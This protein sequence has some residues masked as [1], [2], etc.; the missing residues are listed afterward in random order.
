MELKELIEQVKKDFTK[1]IFK[2]IGVDSDDITENDADAISTY[3]LF[4]TKS[5]KHDEKLG[6]EWLKQGAAAGDYYCTYRLAEC[7]HTGTGTEVDLE[8][9]LYWYEKFY[10]LIEDEEISEKIAIQNGLCYMYGIGTKVD[11]LKA[12]EWFD[13][14]GL[15]E[16]FVFDM[17]L[18]CVKEKGSIKEDLE[19]VLAIEDDPVDDEE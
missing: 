10:Y 11:K 2:E 8:K 5:L 14:E 13:K 6:F 4:N 18:E 15:L 7:Y 9:F 17:A 3:Y 12:Y 19:T 16:K 1:E